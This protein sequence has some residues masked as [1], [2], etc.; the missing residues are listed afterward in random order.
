[1]PVSDVQF[2]TLH[3]KKRTLMN[4]IKDDDGKW[5]CSPDSECKTG[6]T[7][8]YGEAMCSIHKKVRTLNNLEMCEGE[9]VCL[10]KAQ[11][12]G[13]ARSN[14]NLY[15][16]S[17]RTSD[18]QYIPYP[19]RGR[20]PASYS[21]RGGHAGYR[22]RKED[23]PMPMR[24]AL[25]QIC[26]LHGKERTMT[27]LINDRGRWVC[28]PASECRGSSPI[29]RDYNQIERSSP[30]DRIGEHPRSDFDG[31]RRAYDPPITESPERYNRRAFTPPSWQPSEYRRGSSRE[32]EYG[33]GPRRNDFSPPRE[34]SDLFMSG[35]RDDGF[36]EDR[37]DSRLICRIHGK[38]RSR[39]NMKSIPGGGWECL[40]N[41]ACR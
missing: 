16:S 32:R 41:C 24:T 23:W 37:R 6:G 28:D 20:N 10:Q 40:R 36:V 9:W 13:F 5:V 30:R 1:M 38:Y 12:K 15:V 21:D 2:C 11:C 8:G 17:Y 19:E 14:Q 18:G 22:G 33:R 35:R 25:A 39:S 34:R 4:L 3:R 7:G 31:Y 27:Y 29:I 26:S